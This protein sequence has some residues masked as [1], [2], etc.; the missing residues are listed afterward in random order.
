[1]ASFVSFLF[2]DMKPLDWMGK[3]SALVVLAI[4]LYVTILIP[5]LL[6]FGND[7]APKA[8]LEKGATKLDTKFASWSKFVYKKKWSFIVVTALIIAAFIP[9]MFKIT[10]QLDY[11]TIT[12]DKM[13]Y[14][15]ETKEMLKTKLGNQY[16]YEIMISYDEEGAF[17]KPENMKALL[18]HLLPDCILRRIS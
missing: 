18:L 5:I 15:R 7:C 2:V 9:G 13:S 4:Y 8:M 17:K 16:S 1:M 6:S 3:T 14:I 10:A 12:G 11:L